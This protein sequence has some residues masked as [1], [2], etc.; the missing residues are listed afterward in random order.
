MVVI[1]AA[2]HLSTLLV[3]DRWRVYPVIQ[4]F[5]IQPITRIR[6][7]IHPWLANVSLQHWISI[8]HIEKSHRCFVLMIPDRQAE[9]L[10]LPGDL[11][12]TFSQ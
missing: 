9:Q 5:V 3:L 8:H 6:S 12:N 7:A 4:G 11:G 10:G 2:V 1:F